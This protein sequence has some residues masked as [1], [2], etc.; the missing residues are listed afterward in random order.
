MFFEQ[1]KVKLGLRSEGVLHITVQVDCQ[2]S[3]A[4]IR[5]QRNLA[6]GVRAHCTVAEVGIAVRH[7]F[8]QNRVPEKHSGLRTAPCVGYDFVPQRTGVN[9]L[10]HYRRL[11]IYWI[12]LHKGLPVYHTLHEFV[13]DFHRHVGACNLPLLQFCVNKAFRIRMFYRNRKHQRSSSAALGHLARGVRIA[14]H[15]WD[16][17][18]R[19]QRTVLHRTA[20]RP[21][22]AQIVSHAATA[23]HQL[24]LLLVY[25]HDAAVRI[26]LAAVADHKTI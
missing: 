7:R 12:L 4:V 26:A 3:A 15:E 17:A 8:A 20:A 23:F 13:C 16:N 14:F 24:H 11:R 22:M 1:L 19:R 5:T 2:Q 6:A 9:L 21:Y 10:L 18:R 25:L